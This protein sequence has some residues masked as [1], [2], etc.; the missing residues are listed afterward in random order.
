MENVESNLGCY[1]MKPSDYDELNFFFDPVK[2]PVH[3]TQLLFKEAS[4]HVDPPTQPMQLINDYHDNKDGGKVHTS[5]WSLEGVEGLPEDGQLD[6]SKLGLQDELSMRVRVGRNLTSFPLP[7]AMTKAD[8]I[9]FESTM[10]K[11]FS[12]L[13]KNKLYGGKVCSPKSCFLDSAI[14]TACLH[15][16]I[17]HIAPN[18]RSCSR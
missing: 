3:P 10:L 2:L 6:L 7:G 13:M 8:R 5:S 1:A 9:K 15:G 11:A 18:Y 16:M 4:P 12:V 14:R 17:I